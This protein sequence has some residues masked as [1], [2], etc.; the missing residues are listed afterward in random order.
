MW[1]SSGY[2]TGAMV[3]QNWTSSN[4]QSWQLFDQKMNSIGG[5]DTVK[6][7]M[8]QICIFP[9]RATD[10]ELRD[11]IAA[12][13]QHTNPGTCDGRRLVIAGAQ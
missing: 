5:R 9:E 6:A 12:A 2:G 4:S 3:V 7:I 11:M 1:D 13:R 10:Q 8:L